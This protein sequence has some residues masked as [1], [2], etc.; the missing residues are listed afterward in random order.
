MAGNAVAKRLAL[1]HQG[2]LVAVDECLDDLQL[3]AEVSPFIQS[4]LRVRLQKVA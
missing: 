3:V 2:V 1:Q 4:L